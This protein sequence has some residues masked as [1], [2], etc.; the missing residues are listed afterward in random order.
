MEFGRKLPCHERY[1]GAST[2]DARHRTFHTKKQQAI[3]HLRQL[4]PLTHLTRHNHVRPQPSTPTTLTRPLKP[5]TP[6]LRHRRLNRSRHRHDRAHQPQF[7]RPKPRRRQRHKRLLLNP[8]SRTR[9]CRPPP[10][11]TNAHKKGRQPTRVL[12]QDG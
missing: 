6:R 5:N 4:L 2:S 12:G 10:R 3:H 1:L 11:S 7:Q 9:P 8:S